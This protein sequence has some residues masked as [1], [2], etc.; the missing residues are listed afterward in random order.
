M[1]VRFHER[2]RELECEKGVSSRGF[3]DASQ[4]R[5]WE[6]VVE[7]RANDVVQATEAQWPE[8][9]ALYTPGECGLQPQQIADAVV[10]D[11]H[12]GDGAD[13]M[14]AQATQGEGERFS[15]GPVEPLLVVDGQHDRRRG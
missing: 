1:R 10:F 11:T 13:A 7:L 5:S 2:T 4:R 12:R 6:H 9:A 3:G 14:F 8:A 15:G